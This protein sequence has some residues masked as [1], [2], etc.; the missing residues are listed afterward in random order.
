MVIMS[1]VFD[2]RPLEVVEQICH[3]SKKLSSL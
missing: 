1:N 3:Q 2:E